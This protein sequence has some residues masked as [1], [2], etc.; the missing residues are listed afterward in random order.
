MKEQRVRHIEIREFPEQ[1]VLRIREHVSMAELPT[2][3]QADLRELHQYMTTHN[4]SSV[5][6]P[7]LQCPQPDETRI[8]DAEVGWPIDRVVSSDGR[9]EAATLPASRAAWT[10][11]HGSYDTID[12]TYAA[13]YE[14]I[15]RN[16][17]TP[18]GP[19]REVYLTGPEVTDPAKIVTEVIAPIR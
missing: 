15:G 17:H 5:G 16:G 4:I 19:A 7:Y 1:R 18:G 8:V 6:A 11:H 3:I 10:E 12:K 9:I 2:R 14:W 13:L